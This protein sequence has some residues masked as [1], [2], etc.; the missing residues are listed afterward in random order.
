[1][2]RILIALV[3]AGL[4]LWLAF[5]ASVAVAGTFKNTE[6]GWADKAKELAENMKEKT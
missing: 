4:F 6:Q 1:M 3:I 2:I 5:A